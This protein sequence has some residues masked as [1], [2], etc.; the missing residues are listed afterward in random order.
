M[1]FFPGK[2]QVHGILT[3]N[4]TAT[5]FPRPSL[6]RADAQTVSALSTHGTAALKPLADTLWMLV[7]WALPITVAGV[8]AAGAIGSSRL[9]EEVRSRVQQRLAQE[10]P[11]LAVQVQGASLVEGEGIVVRGVSLVDPKLAKE[12]QQML[13]VDEVRLAC[14]TNLTDLISGATRISAVR[15]RRPVLHAVRQAQGGWTVA[16]LLGQRAGG[17]PLIP[18]TIEDA[19]LFV[20]DVPRQTRVAVRQ[21][22]LD[23]QPEDGA[24]NAGWASVRGTAAGDLFERAS[25]AG[26]VD[27]GAGQFDLRG[28][29]QKF[30]ITPRLVDMLPEG[31][32]QMADD[33]RSR[34]SGLRGRVSMDWQAAGAVA[35][36]EATVFSVAGRLE[37]GR[38][39]HASLPFA[40]SDVTAAFQ[41]DRTGARFEQL[42]AHA[43]S[44]LLRGSGRYAGWTSAADFELL[45]EAERLVVG[46][47]WEGLLPASI[48]SQWSK[49]LPAGEV[50]VR[51]QVARRN[52]TIEP[53]VSLR[54]RNVS[55]T[56]YRFPYRLDRTVGTVV[57][58]G[59]TLSIHLTGQAGGHPVHVQGS[60]RTVAAAADANEPA[61]TYGTLEVR[62][63]SMRID[64]T[65][66]AAMPL[67]SA[68]I[69]RTLRAS[70]MF[71]FVFRHDRA[72]TLP[73]GHANSLGIRLAQC[74]MAYA[75]FPYPLSNVSGSLRM[76]RGHWTIR[77]ITGSNDTGVVRCN[78]MLV[79]R[80][81][82]DSELTLQLAGTGVVLERELRDALP[83][84]VRQIWDDVDPRGNAEFSAT[85]KHHVKA[86]RTEVEIE[87]TPQGDTVSIEPAW[88]PYRLERLRGQLHW[89]DGL[90]TFERVRGTH[91][92][93]TVTAG[94]VCRFVPGGGWHVSFEQLSADRFRADHDVLHAL[95]LGLQQ[96]ISAVNLRGLLSL[97]GSLDIH[98]TAG[99][100][101][102]SWD[103][104]L[105]VEQGS[106]DVGTPLEHVHGGIRLRGQS[107]KNAWQTFGDMS[108][109]SAMWRGIQLT[110]V[111]GPLAMDAGGVRMG[112]T[113]ARAGEQGTP[114]RVSARV[115]GG[116]LLLDGSVAA[117]DP[118][119]F[120]LAASLGDAD[121]ERLA[122]DTLSAAHPYRGRVF[123]TVEV[124]GSRAGA[125]SLVGRGQVRLRDAD[126]YELPLVVA[127][128]KML[129]VKAPDL[130]AFGSSVV[131]FRIEGPHAYLDNI[132]LSGDA[133]SLVGNG[134]ID[135][136]SNVH[137]TFRSIMGDSATQLPAMKRVLGGASGQFMLIHV[138]GTLPH[139]E[140]TSEAFPT[141]AAAIQK[142]QSQR[143][144]QDGLRNA[145]LRR[146]SQR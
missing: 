34:I 40:M 107:D 100:P 144:G 125:H 77:D 49:L 19:T 132:E 72:P 118:G 89:K 2:R 78:G 140:M 73:G 106:L 124:S 86:R 136:D 105:D 142:L 61:G 119:A 81:D 63:D 55:L 31:A 80:G 64:D 127:M 146:E 97:A 103:M 33:L 71:D 143:R 99:S 68:D 20:D 52:G 137:M 59:K 85:V 116:T 15:L 60:F 102:A 32:G 1:A 24:T 25:F 44:T 53:N 96:A 139:P 92:R 120:A 23:V 110:A 145:G 62:G 129:R 126:I 75:G 38:F 109:D 51:A 18:V 43:G 5:Y 114:R 28:A 50:D 91:D 123:S 30:E 84:G 35:A 133:I 11:T 6:S 48:A 17:A 36:L 138:D 26:R 93:T 70:G 74:S 87:A 58:E 12:C 16:G 21:I 135:F 94:G 22:T 4:W 98:S 82:N 3:L 108:I 10:F 112:A 141:L 134:E 29:V 104:Q 121:L 66:L 122:G 45:L 57:L 27:V 39:E 8:L 131:D 128:L 7:R 9:G 47:H 113:A 83:A 115:A 56:H 111:Q 130:N 37:S 88:F 67:R 14:S 69:I 76:D 41:V 54:C 46:R 90:L 95:P 101:A 13:W 117:G 65:L 79:P 42:E